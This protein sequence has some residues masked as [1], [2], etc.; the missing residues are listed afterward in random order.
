MFLVPQ[1]LFKF[2]RKQYNQEQYNTNTDHEL[3]NGEAN[4]ELE[5]WKQAI[6]TKKWTKEEE[7][8]NHG[9][10]RMRTNN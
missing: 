3:R 8:G 2:P 10:T 7:K 6:G 1:T 4:K 9:V 5:T